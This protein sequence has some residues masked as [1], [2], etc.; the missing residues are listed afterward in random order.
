MGLVGLPRPARCLGQT[1][2]LSVCEGSG[3]VLRAQDCAGLSSNAHV[4]RDPQ[5]VTTQTRGP[6][7][8]SIRC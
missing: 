1:G 6:P 4:L 5:T 8:C 2:C 7:S 3:G